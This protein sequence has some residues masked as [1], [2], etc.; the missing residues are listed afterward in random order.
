MAEVQHLQL[1]ELADGL[2]GFITNPAAAAESQALQAG[3]LTCE[4]CKAQVVDGDDVSVR[5]SEVKLLPSRKQQANLM[6][7]RIDHS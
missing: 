2:E 1:A 3:N 7:V 6:S 4:V 5:V